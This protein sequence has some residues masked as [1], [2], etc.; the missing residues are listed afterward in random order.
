MEVLYHVKPYFVGIFPYICLIY[1]RYLHFRILKF[2]LILAS[3]GCLEDHPR[4]CLTGACVFRRVA[5]S[6]GNWGDWDDE[7][8]S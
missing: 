8:D 4:T 6:V 3:I 2:P 5:G 1:G 7:I